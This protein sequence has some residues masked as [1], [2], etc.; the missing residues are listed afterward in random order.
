MRQSTLYTLLAAVA[1]AFAAVKNG[2][3]T[4]IRLPMSRRARTAT[5]PIQPQQ[6][7]RQV[8]ASQNV[9]G[10]FDLVYMV[11]RKLAESPLNSHLLPR[12]LL[13]QYRS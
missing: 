10:F 6:E 2:G 11:D 3:N 7:R 1:T 8:S 4:L 5:T 13:I 9:T 12:A